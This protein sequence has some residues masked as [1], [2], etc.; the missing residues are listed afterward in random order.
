MHRSRDSI[1]PRQQQVLSLVS[2]GFTYRQAAEQLNLAETTVKFHMKELCKRLGLKNRA[3]AI[4]Y[5]VRNA[6]DTV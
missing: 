5:G 6:A 1:T 4:A 2:S 3:H